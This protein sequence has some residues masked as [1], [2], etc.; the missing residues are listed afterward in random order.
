MV[1]VTVTQRKYTVLLTNDVSDNLD[2]DVLNIS[3]QVGRRVTKSEVL[4]VLISIMHDD[5][6]LLEKVTD[7]L[8]S[9][10]LDE[11]ETLSGRSI[12]MS[13]RNAVLAR[14][15]L[16]CRLCQKPVTIDDL[17]IDHVKPWAL[18]GTTTVENLQVAHSYCNLSK[19]SKV[20]V[21]L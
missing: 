1:P 6:S 15:G 9:F 12:P 10:V 20:N 14:D 2:A 21:S 11:T 8:P 18:G 19:G 7:G 4:R 17:H 13:V 5:P 16:V 3:R